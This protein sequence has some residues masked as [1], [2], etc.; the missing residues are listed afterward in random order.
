MGLLAEASQSARVV[1]GPVTRRDE[2]FFN[3][4]VSPVRRAGRRHRQ[5]P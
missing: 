5:K 2:T 4:N 1:V 3:W